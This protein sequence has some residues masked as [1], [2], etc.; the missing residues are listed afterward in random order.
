[1]SLAG[2]KDGKGLA[3]SLVCQ[4]GGV[5]TGSQV[6]GSISVPLPQDFET[7]AVSLMFEHH[8]AEGAPTLCWISPVTS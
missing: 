2:E 6:A 3:G 1:M 5:P 7:V 8:E 4:E